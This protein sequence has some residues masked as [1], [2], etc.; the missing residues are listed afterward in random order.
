M[1]EPLT[2]MEITAK[3]IQATNSYPGI[4]KE[5]LFSNEKELLIM[6]S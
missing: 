4:N 3:S 1:K 5:M 2:K 6:F